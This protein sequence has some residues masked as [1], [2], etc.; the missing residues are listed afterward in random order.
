M[1]LFMC[2]AKWSDLE[3]HLE[4]RKKRE[5]VKIYSITV[6]M[7]KACHVQPKDKKL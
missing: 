1:C 3:K 7:L 4:R 2:R 5:V 6:G